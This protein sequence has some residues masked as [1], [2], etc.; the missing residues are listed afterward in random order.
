MTHP[1]SKTAMPT[2][3]L[4]LAKRPIDIAIVIFFII[5]LFFITY[6]V[7]IEQL[8]ITDPANFQY[9]LWPPAKMVDLIHWY[10]KNF[11]PPLMARP[12]WWRATIWIDALFFG[13]FYAFAI[14]A[15]IKGKN[16]IRLAS[17]VWASVMLTNVTIILFEEVGGEHASPE[18]MRV[19]MANAAWVI[20]PVIVLWRMWRKASPF[21]S[22]L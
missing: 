2:Q 16:W 12:A 10:G 22:E 14:Y 19:L 15:F 20:F 4:P 6:I 17:I 11:D 13:P 3:T 8:V 9:P 5:N 21:N 7:D 1:P 18:L